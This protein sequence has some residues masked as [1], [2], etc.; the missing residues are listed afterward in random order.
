MLKFVPIILWRKISSLLFV[1]LFN[2]SVIL[3]N[4]NKCNT[5]S[6]G[7]DFFYKHTNAYMDT[8]TD[9]LTPARLL[10]WNKKKSDICELAVYIICGK[11]K[12]FGFFSIWLIDLSAVWCGQKP[13]DVTFS[14]D[15]CK[16]Q[17]PL[18]LF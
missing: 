13:N 18:T 3:M 15:Q 10:V 9:H 16:P 1:I 6:A 12:F 8:K 5:S 7:I 14:F 4:F 11:T 17:V 2:L